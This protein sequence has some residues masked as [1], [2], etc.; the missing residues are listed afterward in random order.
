MRQ[1]SVVVLAVLAVLMSGCALTDV[2]VKPPESGLETPIPGGNA[3]Q[4]V[5]TV[6]FQDRRQNT[7]RCGVQKGGFGNETAVAVCVGNPAEWL[8]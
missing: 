5:V 1:L 6:P 3:R 4:I 8:A 2:N 7:S